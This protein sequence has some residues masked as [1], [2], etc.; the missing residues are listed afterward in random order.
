MVCLVE[1]P[2]QQAAP[3]ETEIGLVAVETSTGAV[4]WDQFRCMPLCAFHCH[5]T[6]SELRFLHG[7]VLQLVSGWR[8]ESAG[9]VKLPA[10]SAIGEWPG[11]A[12]VI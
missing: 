1:A 4:L 3:A 11:C 5:C 7:V 8:R 2:G 12:L 6:D 9:Q 10:Q